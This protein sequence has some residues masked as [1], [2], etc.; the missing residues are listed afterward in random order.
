M[1]A[2]KP[3]Q[4]IVSYCVMPFLVFCFFVLSGGKLI[5]VFLHQY[6][7][8]RGSICQKKKQS[9]YKKKK[10]E[11]LVIVKPHLL[12]IKKTKGMV[13]TFSENLDVVLNELIEF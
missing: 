3:C 1:C 8:N 4:R 11:S 13:L 2:L 12:C 9:F 6:F 10:K 7:F 5:I